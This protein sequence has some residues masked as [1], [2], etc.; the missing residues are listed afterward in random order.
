M[1]I[2]SRCARALATGLLLAVSIA[3]IPA[4]AQLPSPEGEFGRPFMRPMLPSG[5][6]LSPTQEM[7]LQADRNQ[8]NNRL[9]QDETVGGIAGANDMLHTERQLNH[10]QTF[11]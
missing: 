11:R 3:G 8:L 2:T 6:P 4:H 10:L 7:Q 1:P 9:R 5:T